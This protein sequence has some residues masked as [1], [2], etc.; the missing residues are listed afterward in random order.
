MFSFFRKIFIKER[1]IAFID[2]DQDLNLSILIYNKYLQETKT[3]FI[4]QMPENANPPKK[5]KNLSKLNSIYLSGFS[6]K[7]EI[8]DKCIAIYIHKAIIEG[9]T[10]ITVVSSDYDFV[11]IFKLMSVINHAYAHIKFKLI[12]P[13]PLGKLSVLP[14]NVQNIEIIKEVY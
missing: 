5:L 13:H 7:K 6:T 14:H 3:I 8:V 10:N 2:G 11:D 1:S 9:Y 4:R 12:I